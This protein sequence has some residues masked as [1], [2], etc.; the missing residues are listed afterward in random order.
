[1]KNYTTTT[2][3]GNNLPDLR[4]I[5]PYGKVLASAGDE[6]VVIDLRFGGPPKIVRRD[7]ETTTVAPLSG[8]FRSRAGNIFYVR[9]SETSGRWYS[10][11]LVGERWVYTGQR[12]FI[13]LAGAERLGKTPWC[14][15]RRRLR[16]CGAALVTVEELR[17]GLCGAC[18][19]VHEHG[20]PTHGDLRTVECPKCGSGPSWAC[21]DEDGVPFD[22]HHRARRGAFV[23]GRMAELVEDHPP[24]GAQRPVLSSIDQPDCPTPG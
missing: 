17:V 20:E 6:H 7:R 2:T 16:R 22:G 9:R 21:R 1:M 12:A 3:K 19:W 13:H 18:A 5:V 23:A 15:R 10:Q 11:V 4:G 8:V 14:E 24:L